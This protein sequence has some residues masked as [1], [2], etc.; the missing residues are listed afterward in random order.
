MG[1]EIRTDCK[2]F[3]GDRPC[4][5]GGDCDGCEH[6]L[7]KGT[8]IL[9]VKLAAAGD[10]L[11][12]AAVLPPL[13]KAH[14]QSHIAW[15]TDEPALPLLRLN[16][17]V[18][19]VFVFGFQ[20]WLMLSQQDFDLVICLDKEPRACAFASSMTASERRG[21]TLSAG[22]A[23]EPANE[24]AR[25]DFELGLSNRRK[26]RENTR[27]YPDILCEAAGLPYEGE[28][29]ELTLPE[30]SMAAAR[31]FVSSLGEPE[32]LIGLNV[33]AGGVFARKAW[34]PK[35]FAELAR[36]VR[37][38]LGGTAV[39]LGGPDDR[40]RMIE[41]LDL[42]KGVAADGGV[43]E[44]SEFAAV[45][46]VLDAVVTGDT[47]AMHIAIALG[48]PV[49]ALFGPTVEQEIEIYGPGRKIVTTAECAPCYLRSCD[50]TPSCMD[51]IMPDEVM[52]AVEE[53]LGE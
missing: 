44:L 24:G 10:V 20:S 6:Y 47:M 2:L 15:V 34:T 35:G 50:R 18:D 40:D 12:T 52:S 4:A 28:P 8:R 19:D 16:P 37:S 46:G 31:D 11:R 43:H 38:R 21:Y 49:V 51:A 32:P 9:V 23:V 1:A 13:K 22:G 36:R 26:F 29:Y 3:I 42:S 33:G 41:V 39:V 48:V 14:P 25:Y 7:P 17:Y 30:E 27:T 5:W 53:M 45:V